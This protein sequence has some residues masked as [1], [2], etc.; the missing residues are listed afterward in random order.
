MNKAVFVALLV[1]VAFACV[2]EAPQ[3]ESQEEVPEQDIEPDSQ[4]EE[5]IDSQF[6]DPA[7]KIEIGDMI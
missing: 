2:K 5:F 1:L 7:E 3:G 4:T 6:V